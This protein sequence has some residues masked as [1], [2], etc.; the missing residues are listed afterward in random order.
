MAC[1]LIEEPDGAIKASFRSKPP[2]TSGGPFIDVR[3]LAAQLD[4]GGH[5]HAAGATI[6]ASMTE[7]IETVTEVVSQC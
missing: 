3:R 7:A 5:V 6:E 4:G 2:A 1:L